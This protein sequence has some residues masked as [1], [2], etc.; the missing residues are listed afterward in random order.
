VRQALAALLCLAAC[1]A[2][3][4]EP[5]ARE[6]PPPMT[7]E[8]QARG[9]AL[10]EGY[11]TR[12]CACAEEDASLKDPCELARAQPEALRLP[13]KML[14]GSEGPLNETERRLTEAAARKIIAACVKSDGAL[15]LD[16]CPRRPPA[17]GPGR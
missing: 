13:L 16:R 7:Q 15:A 8:E 14:G 12:L 5:K 3:K 1:S 4:A 2:E 6:G 9:L 17:P 11:V 10:C